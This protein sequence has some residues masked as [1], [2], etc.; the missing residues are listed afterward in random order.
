MLPMQWGRAVLVRSEVD[1]VMDVPL[2]AAG[3]CSE[4]AAMPSAGAAIA[5]RAAAMI[6]S[7][8][9]RDHSWC[10]ARRSLSIRP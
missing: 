7:L 4:A 9:A 3:A 10:G 5:M 2:H 1:W 8:A 6:V